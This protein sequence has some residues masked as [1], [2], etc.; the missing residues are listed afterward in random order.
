MKIFLD[1]GFWILKS[2][3]NKEQAK[4]IFFVNHLMPASHIFIYKK[5]GFEP[6][7]IG[8]FRSKLGPKTA[9]KSIFLG[10]GSPFKI[11]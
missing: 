5:F 9:K 1:F 3:K 8:R 11:C 10:F 7:H 6:I 2:I 4:K